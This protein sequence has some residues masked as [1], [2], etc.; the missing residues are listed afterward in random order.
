MAFFNF[1]HTRTY[2]TD[3]GWLIKEINRIK[4][5]L[6]QYLE[7]AV[8]TFADP[9]TWDITKQYPAMTCVIDSD[10]TAY[11]SKQPVPA[12]VDISNTNYWMPIFNYNDSINDLRANIGANERSSTTATAPRSVNELVWLEDTLY[13]VIADMPAGTAYVVGSNCEVCTVS[14]M[15]RII[16]TMI[17]NVSDTL[18]DN[19]QNVSDTL[20]VNIAADEGAETTSSAAREENDLVWLSGTLYRVT[21]DMTAGTAYVSGTNCT[22]CSVSDMIQ[23]VIDMIN[24][25]AAEHYYHVLESTTASEINSEL[26]AYAGTLVIFKHQ[27]YEV[28]EAIM[29]PARSRIDMN[30]AALRRTNGIHNIM[31]ITSNDVRISNGIVDGRAWADGLDNRVAVQRFTNILISGCRDIVLENIYSTGNCSAEYQPEGLNAPIL[32]TNASLVKLIDC[33]SEQDGGSG[34]LLD[35]AVD[36]IIDRYVSL[37]NAGSG[38]T[39]GYNSHVLISNSIV[40][41]AGT[42]YPN[43]FAGNF[44]GFSLNGDDMTCVNC[45]AKSCS[46]SGF[47][48]GHNVTESNRITFESCIS[49]NNNLDG[50]SFGAH[51][52]TMVNCITRNNTRSEVHDMGAANAASVIITGCEFYGNNNNLQIEATNSM[53]IS[54]SLLDNTILYVLGSCT[55]NNNKF[56]NATNTN[57]CCVVASGATCQCMGNTFYIGTGST[58]KAYLTLGQTFSIYDRPLGMS[59]GNASGSGVLNVVAYP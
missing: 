38:L 46:G 28:D 4:D 11:L 39:G 56:E 12:G 30:G 55:A 42:T 29:I 5:L 13:R 16:I 3:L 35:N 14:D 17:E 51:H 32:V 15:V 43:Y 48:G 50:F 19:I 9:I 18:S 57:A 53:T 24:T 54:S 31:E 49:E 59:I 7:N 36:I 8:I 44:T 52:M 25:I 21:V 47:I 2:D 27:L 34:I 23:Y 10:G 37:D 33:R 6:N 41:N 45:H 20:R 1:P 40:I 22:P 26:A 58:P